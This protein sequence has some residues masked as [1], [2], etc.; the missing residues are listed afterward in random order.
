MFPLTCR[1]QSLSYTSAS[2]FYSVMI[3]QKAQA[4]VH[5]V[6][7]IPVSWCR[8][9]SVRV[10]RSRPGPYCRT[11]GQATEVT[12]ATPRGTKGVKAVVYPAHR[13][14]RTWPAQRASVIT[15]V[16]CSERKLVLVTSLT[17][18]GRGGGITA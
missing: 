12:V 13:T 16:S 2:Y 17:G 6:A 8:W 1:R 9:V 11:R 15:T 3:T 5:V 4:V 10:T 7:T 18:G 14:G